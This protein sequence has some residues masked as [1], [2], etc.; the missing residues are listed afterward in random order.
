[1]SSDPPPA[2]RHGPAR[3]APLQPLALNSL[4]NSSW[5]EHPTSDGKYD[6]E[7]IEELEELDDDPMELDV[8]VD[9]LD[10]QD[11]SAQ[12]SPLTPS[13]GAAFPFGLPDDDDLDLQPDE[14]DLSPAFVDEVE[15][16]EP[17]TE[18]SCAPLFSRP[19]CDSPVPLSAEE[20]S[21]SLPAAESQSSTLNSQPIAYPPWP[22]RSSQPFSQRSSQ[23]TR[24][25]P[26]LYGFDDDDDPVAA[27]PPSSQ[28]QPSQR[29]LSP[30]KLRT[31]PANSQRSRTSSDG[32]T[33][34]SQGSQPKPKP[35]PIVPTPFKFRP[36]ERVS[37]AGVALTRDQRRRAVVEQLEKF[38]LGVLDQV[39]DDAA[40]LEALLAL[41]PPPD[42]TEPASQPSQQSQGKKKR[43]PQKPK[44]V[45][46][47]I[48]VS[49][50][51]SPGSS[52]RLSW[53]SRKG[54]GCKAAANGK[55]LL[56]F[57]R[58]IEYV[59]DG[60]RSDTVSTKREL[61]YRDPSLFGAQSTVDTI[62]EDLSASLAVRRHELNVTAASKG[63]FSGCLKITTTDHVVH[64]GGSFGALTPPTERI[65]SIDYGEEGVRWVL[66]VEKEAVFQSLATPA[67]YRDGPI[68][69]GV[70]LTGKGYPDV[71][72]R[73]L[74]RRL[75]ATLPASVPLLCLVDSDP[76][77]IHILSTYKLGST[78]MQYDVENLVTPR[79]E[80]I[81][82]KG[83]EWDELVGNDRGKLI[84]LTKADRSRAIGMLKKEDVP[85]EWKRELSHMLHWGA[86]A[87]IEVLSAIKP[88]VAQAAQQ[89][90]GESQG[91]SQAPSS[92]QTLRS[93]APAMESETLSEGEGEGPLE[94]P[95]FRYLFRKIGARLAAPD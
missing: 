19:R 22:Q 29:A 90:A 10:S 11:D 52:R 35:K 62:V 49:N 21:Q 57:V 18:S 64:E 71:A 61:Y 70:V 14:D 48:E 12:Q 37:A 87:E 79:L 55:T 38:A 65:E 34:S 78:G 53:P 63:L 93:E 13:S 15:N 91:T 40:L 28:S 45:Q 5:D 75:D 58:V 25:R 4:P 95:L 33:G 9:D 89:L 59:L 23:R 30:A 17:D 66:V 32:T 82:V 8:L 2:A 72:S 94:C 92:S 36:V 67:F 24:K 54:Q 85:R 56:Q 47:V 88:P 26:S 77:G 1:M 81:G 41:D 60:L 39:C 50:R 86:K 80:W 68:G 46:V 73:E 7:E 43:P 83:T 31:S 6:F 44:P 16:E 27:L 3:R 76:H 74:L 84:T 51:S 69:R 42:D 20:A